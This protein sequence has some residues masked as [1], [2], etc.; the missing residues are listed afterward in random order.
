M[1][2]TFKVREAY[3]AKIPS[4]SVVGLASDNLLGDQYIAIHRG[5][6]ENPIVAGSEVAAFQGQDV[7]KIMA[8]MGQE[9][10]ALQAIAVRAA[11]LLSPCSAGRRLSSLRIPALPSR[12]GWDR[13]NGD[14]GHAIGA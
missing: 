10:D 5:H 6:S 13:E 7:S 4:D 14:A 3:V 2:L 12:R 9:F 1:K 11:R 8:R